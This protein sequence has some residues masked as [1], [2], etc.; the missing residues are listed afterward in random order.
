MYIKGIEIRKIKPNPN[1]PRV[2]KDSKFKSLVKSIK[3][4]PEMLNLRPIVI[5]ENYMVLGGNMRL[6]ACKEI[7][8]EKVPVIFIDNLNDEQKNEFILK[9]NNSY[10]E[11]DFEILKSEWSGYD[12]NDWGFDFEFND[13]RFKPTIDPQTNYSDITPEDI[14]KA[15]NQINNNVK[16]SRALID[17]ICPDC[18]NEFS[19]EK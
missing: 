1:N 6:K 14:E 15:S 18:G 4:F 11:W 16:G 7:G 8:M 17:I 3:E 2:I 9:D 19:I 10:G 13:K 12:L 5:D